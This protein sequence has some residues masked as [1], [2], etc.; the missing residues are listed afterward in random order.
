[1]STGPVVVLTGST[2]RAGMEGREAAATRE[3]DAVMREMPGFISAKDYVADDGEVLS[4]F[5]F[6]SEDAL[7]RWR[8]QPRHLEF[9]QVTD[10]YYESFW[11]QAAQV[12]RSYLWRDGEKKPFPDARGAAR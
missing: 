1:M 10:D 5:T 4:V 12:Y 8:D 6:A 3:L 7:L 11:V 9:Q 2:V